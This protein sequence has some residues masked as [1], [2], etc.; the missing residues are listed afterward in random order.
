M[1]LMSRYVR[2]IQKHFIYTFTKHNVNDH[3]KQNLRSSFLIQMY[4]TIQ[5][6]QTKYLVRLSVVVVG[7]Y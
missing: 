7:M 2:S 1:Q 4:D 3:Y 6:R 5:K